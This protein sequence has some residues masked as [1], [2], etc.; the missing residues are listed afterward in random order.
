MLPVGP[1]QR[2]MSAIEGIADIGGFWRKMARSRMTKLR[3]GVLLATIDCTDDGA[4]ASETVQ[5]PF[6]GVVSS[7]NDAD[8]KTVA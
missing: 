6:I 5:P 7:S 3:H 4:N 8:L 1:M 2:R